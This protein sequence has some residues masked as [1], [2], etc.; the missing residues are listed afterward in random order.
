MAVL[1]MWFQDAATTGFSSSSEKM[2]AWSLVIIAVALALQALFYMGIGIGALIA[3]KKVQT[4]IDTV[5]GELKGTVG[6]VTRDLKVEVAEIKSKL[7]PVIDNVNHISNTAKNVLADAEPKLKVITEHLTET[8]RVVRDSAEKLGQT[9]GDANS[10]TQRQ[11]A[12]V[13]G[14]VTAALNTTADVVHAI[15][16]G[17][18][19]P[20]QKIA[21]AATEARFVAEGLLDKLK[22]MAS[23]L[24]FMQSKPANKIPTGPGGYRAPVQRTTV[25]P[26]TSATSATPMSTPP[27]ATGAVPLVK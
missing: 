13:D 3:L 25:Y 10:K 26:A 14:M 19:V 5:R 11:V 18:K 2:I 16:H 22:G 12:R 23:S 20:A 1:A 27:S 17:I 9:V 6:E 8:S 15:E 4:T 24:P 7:Y 21:V